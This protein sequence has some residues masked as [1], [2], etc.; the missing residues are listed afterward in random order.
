MLKKLI[1]LFVL[2][3]IV[4]LEAQNPPPPPTARRMRIGTF[5]KATIPL[6]IAISDP[7]DAPDPYPV[8]SA[9]QTLKYLTRG[10]LPRTSIAWTCTGVPNSCSPASGSITAPAAALLSGSIAFTYGCTSSGAAT[11]NTIVLTVNDGTSPAVT[12]TRRVSCVLE[13]GGNGTP[14]TGSIDAVTSPVT[15]SSYHITGVADD[16]KSGVKKVEV[17]C[18]TCLTLQT[19]PTVLTAPGGSLHTTFSA[20]INLKVGVNSGIYATITDVADNQT[21]TA[22][23]SITRNLPILTTTTALDPCREGTA[24][25]PGGGGFQLTHNGGGT[26]PYTWT[27]V[28][29]TFP[30]SPTHANPAFAVSAGGL[31][32]GTPL[33][34]ASSDCSVATP[35]SFIFRVTDALAAAADTPPLPFSCVAAGA[36]TAH[37]YFTDLTGGTLCSDNPAATNC[38]QAFNSM[39]DSYAALEKYIKKDDDV[40]IWSSTAATPAVF[41]STKHFT[42]VSQL[43]TT[44]AILRVNPQHNLS[45]SNPDVEAFL[46]G[47][48]GITNGRYRISRCEDAGCDPQLDVKIFT[49]G[50]VAIVGTTTGPV[51]TVDKI[52]DHQLGVGMLVKIGNHPGLSPAGFG[53]DNLYVVATTPTFD[54]FTLKTV[55]GTDVGSTG[56]SGGFSHGRYWELFKSGEPRTTDPDGTSSPGSG[57]NAA[58]INMAQFNSQLP[59][60]I[61]LPVQVPVGTTRTVMYTWDWYPTTSYKTGTLDASPVQDMKQFQFAAEAFSIEEKM[62]YLGRRT[63]IAAVNDATNTITFNNNTGHPFAVGDKFDIVG[64]PVSGL[65]T[66]WTVQ[67][68]SGDYDVVTVED[69]TAAMNPTGTKCG[70]CYA[71]NPKDLARFGNRIY[72]SDS[73]VKLTGP[74]RTGL[75]DTNPVIGTG[76]VTGGAVKVWKN[77]NVPIR[78]NEW[79][80]YNLYWTGRI[81]GDDAVWN[82]WAAA[83]GV[84]TPLLRQ[85]NVTCTAAVGTVMTC[86]TAAETVF[87]KDTLLKITGVVLNGDFLVTDTP[88]ATTFTVTVPSGTLAETNATII[89]YFSRAEM[90]ISSESRD[91]VKVLDVPMEYNPNRPYGQQFWWEFASSNAVGFYNNAIVS[92]A[93]NFV[94]L[95]NP[96]RDGFTLR[97]PVR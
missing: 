37:T 69:I 45:H 55:D 82:A 46:Q 14:P 19:Y 60:N 92:F 68:L 5:P 22:T 97:R 48:T 86:T 42:V 17:K 7:P 1:L 3:S 88:T 96:T 89:P 38:V 56:S 12:K 61:H 62:F 51:G 72:N 84:S 64:W 59:G 58:R 11:I 15:T 80:R 50:G 20:D 30:S 36:E 31:I 81:A 23:V 35:C 75:Q 29:G 39:R 70:S 78:I 27:K 9:T 85:T 47:V 65:N 21:D 90:Y 24:Y 67:S 16:D 91:P 83:T 95:M 71:E 76:N 93:R 10:T 77:G 79:Q 57:G 32:T 43:A 74:G 44:P 52:F 18:P 2:G 33:N 40:T 34:G 66:R 41:Q 53:T 73:F 87:K 6:D 25:G 4:A 8:P 63:S 26:G 54:T 28:S 13:T 94:A 49:T